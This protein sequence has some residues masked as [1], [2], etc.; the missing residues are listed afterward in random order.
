MLA[1]VWLVVAVTNINISDG[2]QQSK[3]LLLRK[4]METVVLPGVYPN[5]SSVDFKSEHFTCQIRDLPDEKHLMC[6][7]CEECTLIE[8][9]LVVSCP[10]E[11]IQRTCIKVSA[12]DEYVCACQSAPRAFHQ[13]GEQFH[14]VSD[15]D[16]TIP[17]IDSGNVFYRRLCHDDGGEAQC[18]AEEKI[19]LHHLVAHLGIS[20][21]TIS[22]SSFHNNDENHAAKR[23][24]LGLYT[25]YCCGWLGWISTDPTPWV[26]FDMGVEV[27][28]WGLLL[29]KR[30]DPPYDVQMVLSCDVTFSHDGDAWMTA[31]ENLVASY[32]DGISSAVWLQHPMSGRYWRIHPLTWVQHP[33][34]KADLIGS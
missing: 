23:V 2:Q 9:R 12:A 5:C 29:K 31:A 8:Q 17:N 3:S 33:A 28:V 27:T 11:S 32:P 7:G 21:D 34:M 19:H 18:V 15:W 22:A 1:S 16:P 6:L 30:C 25:D 10:D 13:G 24:R 20:D 4:A 14:W 26:Q